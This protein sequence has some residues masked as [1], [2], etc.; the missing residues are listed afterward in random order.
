MDKNYLVYC[1]QIFIFKIYIL[2]K[3][4]CLDISLNDKNNN[5]NNL[6]MVDRIKI[7]KKNV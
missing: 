3:I 7:L 4:N 2:C 5:D 6:L 1:V